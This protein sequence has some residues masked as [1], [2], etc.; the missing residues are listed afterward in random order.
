MSWQ[1]LNNHELQ[2]LRKMLMLDVSEAAELI[3]KVSNRTWQ[4][5]EAGRN[6]VPADVEM[7]VYALHS[8]M[9]ECIGG[10]LQ[11]GEE[12]NDIRWYHTFEEFK[13]DYPNGNKAWWKVHQAVCA[14]LFANTG[15][16]IEL[17]SDIETDKES[18]IYKFFSR[19]REEDIEHEKQEKLFREKG[20][21]D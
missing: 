16:D 5:W 10:I 11:A 3:G 17:R 4:Y 9:N 15:D 12:N 6:K 7:E 19:T 20:I 8:Q 13:S 21:I 14:D 18:Y 1:E 2:A